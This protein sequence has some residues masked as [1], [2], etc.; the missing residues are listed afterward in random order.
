M[1]AIAERIEMMTR[2]VI[3]GCLHYDLWAAHIRQEGW[4]RSELYR[5]TMPDLWSVTSLAHRYAFYNRFGA[6]YV[7]SKGNNTLPRLVREVAETGMGD[8]TAG[9]AALAEA[10]PIFEKIRHLRNNIYAH[11]SAK[12][13]VAQ[14]YAEAE[15]T[16]DEAAKVSSLSVDVVNGLRDAVGLDAVEPS[17]SHLDQF[18]AML[19]ALDAGL[20]S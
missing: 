17:R 15:F 1:I 20:T 11:Q 4:D 6:A 9:R 8:L 16:L 5:E 13:R 2:N 7:Q 12:L 19:I 18:E 3:A 10:E 14:V